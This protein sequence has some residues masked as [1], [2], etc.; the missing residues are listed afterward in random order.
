VR[1]MSPKSKKVHSSWLIVHSILFFLALFT[2]HCSL[3]TVGYAAPCYGTKMPKENNF[4]LGAQTHSIF[5]RY[6]E[7][8]YGKLRS[9]QHL[10]LLSYGV[11]N[12]LSIDLKAG[13]SNIK[14]HP[15]GSDEVDYNSNFS[16]GYGFRLRLYE[17]NNLKA[18]FGFQHISVHPKS[19]HLGDV[20]NEAI[21]DD[22][23]WS[24]LASYDFKRIMPYLGTKWSRVDYIHKVEDNRKRRM[25]DLTKDIGLVLGLDFSLSERTWFNLE[26]QLFD[27]EALAVSFNYSF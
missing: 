3:F 15:V 8:E 16:G 21:L 19:R 27:G 17:K 7:D 2:V 13:S 22:W 20:K 23:Q 24:I 11:F 10:F 4:F 9:T 5:K 14:Q 25:S 18:V 26:G 12:W 1:S 6:L